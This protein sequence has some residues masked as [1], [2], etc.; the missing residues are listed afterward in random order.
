M[1]ESEVDSFNVP[2]YNPNEGEVREIVLN[3][4]SFEI[5]KI[6]AREHRVTF[7]DD[8]EGDDDHDDNDYYDQSRANKV[9]KKMA[10]V[11]RSFTEPI[12]VAH[13][14]GDTTFINSLFDKFAH[15]ATQHYMKFPHQTTV[16]I[17]LSLIRK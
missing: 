12:L 3:E 9:G 8:E 5:N 7:K 15:H 6:E 2:F 13:F 1:K 11:A 14:G 17:V 4:G 16:N 10:K